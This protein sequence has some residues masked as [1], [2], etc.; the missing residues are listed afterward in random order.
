VQVGL[1][2]CNLHPWE[3]YEYSLAELR[4][5]IVATR[6]IREGESK[7]HWERTR[8]LAFSNAKMQGTLKNKNLKL[9]QF[10]PF[11]WDNTKPKKR[12]SSLSNDERREAF[13]QMHQEAQEVWKQFIEQRS[14]N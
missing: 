8:A 9:E 2:E 13:K 10:W 1:G 6:L 11:P 4:D 7:E 3:F 12:L 5:K 14:T